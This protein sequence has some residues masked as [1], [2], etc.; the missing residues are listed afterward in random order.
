MTISEERVGSLVEG[1]YEAALEPERWRDMLIRA[2]QAIGATGA[3][4]FWVNG[5]GTSL[6]RAEGWNMD[7][8]ALALYE[9]YYITICPRMRMS[10][11]LGAGDVFDDLAVR[12]APTAKDR[13][14]YEFADRYG[15]DFARILLAEH[16]PDLRIGFNF[17]GPIR[18]DSRDEEQ[19]LLHALAPHARRAAHLTLRVAEVAE[20]AEFGDA[21]FEH[22]GAMMVIDGAARLLRLNARAE[23][24]LG[25]RDGLRVVKGH[26]QAMTPADD[27]RLSSEVAAALAGGA[28]RQ[29]PPEGFAL[30]TRPSGRPAWAV[31]AIPLPRHGSGLAQSAGRALLSIAETVPRV[32]PAR[33]RRG[34]GLSSAEAEV[35]AALAG[36]MSL[37]GIAAARRAS[38]GTVRAQVKAVFAKLEVS[39]QAQLVGRVA[40]ACGTA[41]SPPGRT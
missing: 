16:S 23:A 12:R 11:R 41:A 19:A 36:G 17:Y 21:L 4:V 26:L 10:G 34:F 24:V 38:V 33:L 14:Y 2:G 30:V 37:E 6:L 31:S 18:E 27:A 9:S 32:S 39:T 13:E 5:S 40:A 22:S 28:A 35:A 25:S 7:P 3:T 15:Y 8:E 29:P 1:F 20:R